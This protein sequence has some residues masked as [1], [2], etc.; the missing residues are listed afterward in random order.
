M[1]VLIGSESSRAI[2]NDNSMPLSI[3]QLAMCMKY[4]RRNAAKFTAKFTTNCE[5]FHLSSAV[6]DS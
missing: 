1:R 3:S 4:H 2:N 5:S 6:V